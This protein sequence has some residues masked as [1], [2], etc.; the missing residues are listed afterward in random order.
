MDNYIYNIANIFMQNFILFSLEVDVDMYQYRSDRF[1]ED[2]EDDFYTSYC[3]VNEDGTNHY[4][5]HHEI[6]V[7]YKFIDR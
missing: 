7:K 4:I 1:Y 2:E 3:P 6:L 5:G